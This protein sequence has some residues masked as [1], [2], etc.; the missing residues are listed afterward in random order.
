VGREDHRVPALDRVDGDADRR[1]VGLVTG[2]RAMTPAGGC[3]WAAQSGSASMTRLFCRGASR[4]M[5]STWPRLRSGLPCFHS[6]LIAAR[7]DP[8]LLVAASPGHGAAQAIDRGLIGS[9]HRASRPWRERAGR[10]RW[11]AP[12]R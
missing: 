10:R 8:C 9:R 1:D 2:I 6:T 11:P 4:R 5:P 3:D 7:V 12:R